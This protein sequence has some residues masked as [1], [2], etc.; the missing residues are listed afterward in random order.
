[1]IKVLYIY[2]HTAYGGGQ[3]MLS[4]LIEGLDKK[5]FLPTVVCSADNPRFIQELK[6]KK[7]DHIPLET[8]NVITENKLLKA[9]LQLP[10]FIGINLKIAKIIKDKKPDIIHVNLFYSALFSIIPAKIYGK[11]FLW[12][13]QTPSDLLK[14]KILTKFLIAVSD[15]TIITCEDFIKM[16]K[17]NGLNASKLKVIYTGLKMEEFY[18]GEKLAK[19]ILINSREIK[20]PVVAMIAR[21][22]REQKGHKYF[23]EAAKMIKDRFPQTNFLIVGG[24]FSKEEEEFKK[25]LED[26]GKE[27]GLGQNLIFSGFYPDLIGLLYG[28]DIIVIPSSYEAPSAVA[29][30]ASA[31]KKPVVASNAGGI[32]EI[33]I[34]GKTG[35]LVPYKGSKEIAEKVIFLLDHPETAKE[36]GE[37]GR[38]RIKDNF[39]QERL[40][41]SHKFLYNS[42]IRKK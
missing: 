39:S 16:A 25:E 24:T 1:M 22:D 15:K 28:T 41:D 18:Q 23:I 21:F 20:R 11:P 9:V 30:E 6:E 38:E 33:I 31:A 12:V 35:F 29:M 3:T 13:A 27:L 40:A 10:N 2:T 26:K 8:K 19:N 17:E 7:I 34:D 4:R 42:L 37:K 36:F 14:Y 5:E 32:P